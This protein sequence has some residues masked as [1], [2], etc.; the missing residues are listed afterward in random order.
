[1]TRVAHVITDLEVGGAEHVLVRL[2][3]AE[4]AAG[5]APCVVA[6]S[7]PGPLALRLRASGVDVHTL[8][9]VAGRL[10]PGDVPRLVTLLRRARPAVVQTWLYHADVVGGAAARLAGIPVVWGVHREM[11]PLRDPKRAT[12]AVARAAIAMS[13]RVPA[14]VVCCAESARAAHAAAGYP[15]RSLEVI[16][17]GVPVHRS[18]GRR[19]VRVRA[20]LGLAADA[21]VVGRIAR[22]HDDKDY[23]SLIAAAAEVCRHDPRIRFVLVGK[24]IDDANAELVRSLA[25][26]GIADRVQLLGPRADVAA[27]HSALDVA[28]SS[29]RTEAFPLVVAEAMERGVPVVATDVGDSAALVGRGGL[30]VPPGDP[31]ALAAA[32]LELV[33]AGPEHRSRVGAAGRERVIDHFDLPTM[34]DRYRALHD[35]VA[36]TPRP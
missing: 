26:A 4:A 35:R 27:V 22:Y 17:N 13:T 21:V 9:M 18:N 10:R 25:A 23:P 24:G 14:A 15:E 29:S 36:S 32:V 5:F 28:V 20:E 12:R 6:L 11:P 8:G 30:V 7:N 3:E 16:R 1:M 34:V 2:L 33:R 19:G 31:P